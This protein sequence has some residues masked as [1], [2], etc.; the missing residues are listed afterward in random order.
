[1]KEIIKG[2]GGQRIGAVHDEELEFSHVNRC[3]ISFIIK[4]MQIKITQDIA[5]LIKFL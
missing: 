4:Y 3:L 5:F 1:M 2:K